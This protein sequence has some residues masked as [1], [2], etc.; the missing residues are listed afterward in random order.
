MAV[1]VCVLLYFTAFFFTQL[2]FLNVDS[3]AAKFDGGRRS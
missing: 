2:L 1:Y 3:G